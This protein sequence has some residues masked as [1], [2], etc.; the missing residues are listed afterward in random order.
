LEG[1]EEWPDLGWRCDAF[2]IAAANG[3]HQLQG[4]VDGDVVSLVGA[5]VD[6]A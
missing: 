2:P 1:V 6:R 4:G 3:E 5:P